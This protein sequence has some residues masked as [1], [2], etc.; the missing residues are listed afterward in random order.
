MVSYKECKSAIEDK[1]G[2][3]SRLADPA[4]E[5]AKNYRVPGFAGTVSFISSMTEHF[6]GGC[7]R[8]RIMA[9]GNLKVCNPGC[10]LTPSVQ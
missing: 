2:P 1:F 3:L 6:C 8:L 4:T 7:N 9:D 5:V 10:S